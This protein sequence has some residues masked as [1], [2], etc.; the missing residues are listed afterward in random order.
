MFCENM[1]DITY[2]QLDENERVALR[3]AIVYPHRTLKAV[4]PGL[5]K[6]EPRAADSTYYRYYSRGQDKLKEKGMLDLENFPT[7]IAFKVMPNNVLME[8]T[9]EPSKELR[10]LDKEHRQE[11]SRARDLKTE[12]EKEMEVLKEKF[13]FR[14]S[15]D[16]LKRGFSLPF[17][18][19]ID[20]AIERFG[21][22]D[23]DSAIVKAYL[24]SEA[25][26]RTLFRL[27]IEVEVATCVFAIRYASF[28]HWMS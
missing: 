14:S 21:K 20:A 11:E 7:D 19:Y 23:Y 18:N 3:V 17:Q 15:Y 10:V 25:L 12:M 13:D 9:K 28:S 16:E 2:D 6:F 1:Q 26:G 22:G 27:L 8:M 4:L 24:L 5:F